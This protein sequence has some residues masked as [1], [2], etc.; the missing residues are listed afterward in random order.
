MIRRL[1][2]LP[3]APGPPL[4]PDPRGT[5]PGSPIGKADGSPSKRGLSDGPGAT[6]ANPHPIA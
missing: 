2:F 6:G 1:R 5:C 3:V 4:S